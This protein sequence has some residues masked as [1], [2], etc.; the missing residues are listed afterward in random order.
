MGNGT[1]L[2]WINSDM[3]K[4]KTG[5]SEGEK[6]PRQGHTNVSFIA[7]RVCMHIMQIT[8][9]VVFFVKAFLLSLSPPPPLP[10]FSSLFTNMRIL[11]Y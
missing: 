10:L 4:R 11:K 1:L 9:G 3:E 8:L 7:K 6:K 2:R 5:K